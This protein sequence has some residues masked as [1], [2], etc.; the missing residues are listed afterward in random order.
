MK[1]VLDP[2][3]TVKA[4]AME[5]LPTGEIGSLVAKKSFD[6][7]ADQER[8]LETAKLVDTTL[9]RA[10]MF[11]SPSFAGPLFRIDNFCEPDVVKEKLIE[12]GRYNDLVD[13][14][15]GKKLHRQALELLQKFGESDDQ[16]EAASQLSGPQ[17]TVSYLQNLPPEM[18]ELI[19]QYAEWPLRKD[20][21]LGM[22]VFTADTEN[23]EILPRQDVLR[24]L[25]RI[26]RNLAVR[27]LE[28]IIQEL[29]DTTP[30]F[31]QKLVN[32]YI[33]T[34]RADV[35]T[36]NAERDKWQEKT[37][38]FLK[39]GKYQPYKALGLLPKDGRHSCFAKWFRY[40][41]TWSQSQGYMKQEPLSLATWASTSKPWT[42]MC[43][44]SKTH[45]KPKSGCFGSPNSKYHANICH[46]YCNQ[47]YL[48]ENHDTKQTTQAGHTPAA[49]PDD[50]PPS[51]YHTLLSLYLSPLP[52]H[53]PQWG[54][55]LNILAK[56]G[57]RMP[58][59]STLNLIP[60][61]L[62]IKEL[63]SYFQGRIRSA[64]TIVNESR[65][66][67]GLRSTLAFSEESKLRLGDGERGG[68]NRRV[69]VTED[70]VCGVCYKR[71]GGSAIK[72]LPE[73]VRSCFLLLSNILC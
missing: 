30:D 61:T 35:F 55:A 25:Q 4:D 63:E 13:F 21:E 19:L 54:P 43:S 72:V 45:R 37:L 44:N 11:V 68:R 27:Y 41:L 12:A 62:P 52:P 18:I 32:T 34:L 2:D 10:Y 70:R 6:A 17:R 49:D 9:F 67:A 46:R 31:H 29:N 15:Y 47:I 60:E 71:F 36:D 16:S 1:K 66:V 28:H 53:K 23:A 5:I 24:F 39:T 20:P 38:A 48:T 33:E 59:S 57:A 14:F 40:P 22:E 3:G 65:I 56:H 42:F 69:V 51:I 58:A 64:N 7:S 8:L 26:D 50:A 73:Y